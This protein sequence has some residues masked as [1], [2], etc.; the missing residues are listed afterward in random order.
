[1][2]GVIADRNGPGPG[3]GM[4]GLKTVQ[5]KVKEIIINFDDNFVQE[6]ASARG[7]SG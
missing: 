6:S 4:H 1:M 2:H 7:T 5:N 3:V